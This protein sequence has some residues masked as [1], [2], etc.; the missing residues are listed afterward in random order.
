[1]INSTCAIEVPSTRCKNREEWD[2][3]CK[4][5]SGRPH[6]RY[7]VF[8]EMYSNE[9]IGGSLTR[10]S[11]ILHHAI[12][13]DLEPV[14]NGPLVATHGAGDFGDW[15]GLTNNPKFE[16]QNMEGFKNAANQSLP[17][18]Q[19]RL[20]SNN[21]SWKREREQMYADKKW[22]MDQNNRTSVAYIPDTMSINKYERWG[23]IVE[24]ANTDTGV[25]KY[26]RQVL[27]NIFWSVPEQRKRCKGFIPDM[28][29]GVKRPWV[30]AF[31]V[32][33]GDALHAA[34]FR[35][36]P[37]MYYVSVLESV[38]KSIS[39]VDP[40]AS[41]NV[42]VFSEGSE[43][44]GSEIYN[45]KGDIVTWDI[46]DLC[47]SFGISCKMRILT[48]TSMFDAFDCL[49]TADVLITSRSTFSETAA[50]ISTNV[51]IHLQTNQM[52]QDTVFVNKN[53]VVL[54]GHVNNQSEIDT[55]ISDWFYCSAEARQSTN[56][57]YQTVDGL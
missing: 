4:T 17:F 27:R 20:K 11:W 15:M 31:H 10:I 44:Q 50:A 6:N 41:V 29:L 34:E 30:V 8:N 12:S 19:P 49:A 52:Q 25:C 32:R 24:P 37:H 33:R 55:A 28:E 47:V 35:K 48:R 38:L 36:I 1:M 23:S 13:F 45:E 21:L 9:G 5:W 43:L 22:F 39:S 3:T 40:L 42:L 26:A 51:K 16:I 7:I 2:E 14:I 56:H 54:D 18:Y 46:Y 57:F 53:K